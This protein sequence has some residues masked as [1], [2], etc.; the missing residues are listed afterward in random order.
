MAIIV[1]FFIMTKAFDRVSHEQ[2]SPKFKSYGLADPQ[3]SWLA[4]YLSER[5]QLVSINGKFSGPQPI[6]SGE[7]HCG[8]LG[9][10]MLLLYVTDIFRAVCH[11]TPFF[12]A[13]HMKMVYS[14]EPSLPQTTASI[15]GI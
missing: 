11:G 14:F 6:T 9:P 5:S 3:Y 15:M 12:F 7:L 2:L 4:A 1:T 10:L 13:D 8:V